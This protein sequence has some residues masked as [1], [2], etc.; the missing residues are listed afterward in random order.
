MRE[1]INV[2]LYVR[3]REAEGKSVVGGSLVRAHVKRRL[4]DVELAYLYRGE[5]ASDDAEQRWYSE[6]RA[7]A[8][9]VLETLP[10]HSTWR[11]VK[12][13]GSKAFAIMLALA[14]LVTLDRMI[15]M[16]DQIESLIAT[17]GGWVDWLA[18]AA[19]LGPVVAVLV[20]LPLQRFFAGFYD[21][22]RILLGRARDVQVLGRPPVKRVGE[23]VYELEDNLFRALGL[24]KRRESQSDQDFLWFLV[25]LIPIFWWVPLLFDLSARGW[26]ALGAVAG[27]TVLTAG[28]INWR[29]GK[30]SWA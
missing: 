15:E 26:V 10:S 2:L 27:L 19:L 1:Y 20:V 6:A 4:A 3:N 8:H 23:N 17:V 30:R 21:K 16:R 22:R 25:L 12:S 11:T 29:T 9:E 14:G 7:S 13:L 5:A 28:F 18:P 24:S